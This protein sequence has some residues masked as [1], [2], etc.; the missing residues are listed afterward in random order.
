VQDFGFEVRGLGLRVLGSRDSGIG[1]K[2]FMKRVA[3]RV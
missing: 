3:S 2:G 1:V